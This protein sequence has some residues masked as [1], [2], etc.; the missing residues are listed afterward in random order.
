MIKKEYTFSLPNVDFPK[1][2][3]IYYD[4]L[5]QNF[6][7]KICNSLD[8]KVLTTGQNKEEEGGIIRNHS[9]LF[10]DDYFVQVDFVEGRYGHFFE[11]RA[12]IHT[13]NN[14]LET[15]EGLLKQTFSK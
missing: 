4:K 10:N 6:K 1:E 15:A 9:Y 5:R 12:T 8:A 11:A 3:D 7:P 13:M 2:I 14:S